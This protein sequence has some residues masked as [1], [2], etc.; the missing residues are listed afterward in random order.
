MKYKIVLLFFML[1]LLFILNFSCHKTE[2]ICSLP[3][4]SELAAMKAK[5][6]HY[7][8]GDTLKLISNRGDTNIYYC[9]NINSWAEEDKNNTYHDGVCCY[10]YSTRFSSDF[11]QY[12]FLSYE[13]FKNG[14]GIFCQFDLKSNNTIFSFDNS[15]SNVIYMDSITINN[16]FFN[17]IYKI[18]DFKDVNYDIYYSPSAG[19]IK[20][21]I[22]NDSLY[23]MPEEYW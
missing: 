20:L 13:F 21:S 7:H 2:T 23:F 10:V 11:N 18:H 17:E 12:N 16:N 5:W 4:E 14:V 9:E 22:A 1:I 15:Y 3:N 19:L 6:L 8:A